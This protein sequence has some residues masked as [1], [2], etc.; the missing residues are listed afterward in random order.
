MDSLPPPE[1]KKLSVSGLAHT[2]AL[3][4]GVSLFCLSAAPYL[5]DA[6]GLAATIAT[7][8]FLVFTGLL[9]S[10]TRNSYQDDKAHEVIVSKETIALGGATVATAA[11][12]AYL[13]SNI[14]YVGA[15]FGAIVSFG[16]GTVVSGASYI[17]SEPK[18]ILKGIG[19][20][21]VTAVS[22]FTGYKSYQT[23]KTVRALYER[24]KSERGS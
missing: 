2:A 9:G 21:A 15:V 19:V 4:A 12:T 10:V 1:D 3:E 11:A 23:F 20:L 18:A 22:A 13:A 17:V 16:A 24:E 14:P 5:F 6:T 8:S 7:G